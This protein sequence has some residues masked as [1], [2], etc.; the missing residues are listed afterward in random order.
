MSQTGLDWTDNTSINVVKSGLLIHDTE[1]NRHRV[2]VASWCVANVYRV[3][4]LCTVL[5]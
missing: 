4:T 2:S 1:V 3:S 5:G